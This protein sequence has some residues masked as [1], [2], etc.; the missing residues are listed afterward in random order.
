MYTSKI[1]IFKLL[2]ISLI[3]GLVII[4]CQGITDSTSNGDFIPE[5]TS[6]H[7]VYKVGPAGEND[8]I[9]YAGYISP[10]GTVGLTGDFYLNLNNSQLYGPKINQEWRSSIN[11]AGRGDLYELPYSDPLLDD[12]DDGHI[13]HN[14][15]S[16]SQIFSGKE[17]PNGHLGDPGDYYLNTTTFHLHGPKTEENGWMNSLSLEE[18][19]DQKKEPKDPQNPNDLIP[20]LL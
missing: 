17:N 15:A 16:T 2:S 14:G 8:A 6:D 5:G 7:N 3:T 4:S 10:S 11:L 9:L 12:V 20:P 18:L 13:T 1:H 19:E